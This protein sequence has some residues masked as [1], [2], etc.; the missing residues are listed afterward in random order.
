MNSRGGRRL[1]KYSDKARCKSCSAGRGPCPMEMTP[2]NEKG[3][4]FRS[5][6][7]IP[8]QGI[9]DRFNN[10]ERERNHAADQHCSCQPQ[11]ACA[12]E[13][14]CKRS[15][16]PDQCETRLKNRRALL[17]PDVPARGDSAGE[18]RIDRVRS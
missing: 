10:K 13:P 14:S 18:S 5:N 8:K 6:D 4:D 12:A 9:I 15:C 3:A 7:L 11:T 17:P 16:A 2:A 1:S